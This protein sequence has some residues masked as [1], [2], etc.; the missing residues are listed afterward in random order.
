VGSPFIHSQAIDALREG[1][2]T[3]VAPYAVP[4]VMA[5]TTSANLA[6]AFGILGTSYSITSACASSAH[7]IGHAA[8][9]IQ[10]GKQDVVFAGG[11]EE[12]QWTSTMLFDAMGA[13]ATAFNDTPAQS[14]RPFDRRRDGFVISGGAGMLVLEEERHALARGARIYG[15]LAG[16]G[17]T[18][19]GE[20][21]VLPAVDGAARAMRLALEQAGDS[22]DY[23][24]A[25]A[26]STRAGDIAELEAIG[27][28]F[29]E[30]IPA[31]SSTKGLTGHAIAAAG[32][33]EAVFSLLM[34]NHGFI[35]AN[36]NLE[37]PDPEALDFPLVRATLDRSIDAVMTNSF[38]FGG[39][40]ACL[41]FRRH[42]AT[43]R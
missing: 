1:G 12:V 30:R 40:N 6:T 9:L 11:A 39:T 4:Q 37:D 33:Q 3:R 43:G 5:S 35:A 13:L 20:D 16:Y 28:V 26:T 36:A 2:I 41:V 21:M 34:L 22:V 8:E 32:A 42:G 19:D 38:G 18:S 29:G 14:S 23:V 25:H 24:N 17:A 31:I 7:C 10:L 15:E 27:R